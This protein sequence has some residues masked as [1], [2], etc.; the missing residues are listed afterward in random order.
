[1]HCF[2]EKDEEIKYLKVEGDV[3][4]D[5]IWCDDCGNN[6]DIE[7]VPLSQPLKIKLMKWAE[8]YGTWMNRERNQ[9]HKDETQLEDAHNHLGQLLTNEVQKELGMSYKVS[10]SFSTSAKI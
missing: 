8:Q 9:S 4:A 5:A 1:M 10:F 7:E 3:G 2:C 6:L